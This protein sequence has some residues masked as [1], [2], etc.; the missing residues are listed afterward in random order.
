[1]KKFSEY[2]KNLNIGLESFQHSKL[3]LL[4]E[5][6]N[7]RINSD[8]TIYLFGNGGSHANASHVV[9]DY[10]NSFA[11]E[12]LKLK[13]SNL[14]DN[15]CFLTAAS[16]DV[17]FEDAYSI[18]FSNLIEVNDLVIYLSGSGNSMNL[19]K[20]A[21]LGKRIKDLYQVSITAYNGGALSEIV[22]LPLHIKIDDM[23]IAEDCQLIIFH[24]LKQMLIQKNT[25]QRNFE[26]INKYKKRTMDDLIS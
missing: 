8:N 21:R 4:S 6:I 2:L 9:G 12:G 15:V 26:L 11:I 1:M 18:L 16:N 10:L 7:K 14:A 23:E 25:N 5:E 24:Y 22:D 20:C 19:V 13:I 17:S 3:N